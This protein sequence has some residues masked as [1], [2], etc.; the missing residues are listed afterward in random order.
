MF[1]SEHLHKAIIAK[2]PAGM[3]VRVIWVSVSVS[4]VL[5]AMCESAVW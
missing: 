4:Y 2:F 5:C 3:F 1:A